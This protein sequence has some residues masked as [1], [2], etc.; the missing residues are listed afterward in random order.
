MHP[1]LELGDVVAELADP[2]L[3]TGQIA[4][5]GNLAADPPGGDAD[6]LDRARMT[7]AIGVGEVEAEDIDAGLDQA[8]E[9]G[10]VPARGADRGDDLRPPVRAWASAVFSACIRDDCR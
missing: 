3:R 4:E 1:R 7:L 2:H 5:H 6:R 8:L 10:R 9:D